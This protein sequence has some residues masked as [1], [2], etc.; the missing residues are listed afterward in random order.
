MI[1]AK[2]FSMELLREKTDGFRDPVLVKGLFADSPA[3]LK[4]K[5]RDYLA[6]SVI[7]HQ[8]I[9]VVHGAVYKKQQNNRTTDIFKNAFLNIYDNKS[10]KEYLF[11]PG[12]F[13]YV[14][15]FIL[16]PLN[17]VLLMRSSKQNRI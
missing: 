13:V 6:N 2:D 7:G 17:F 10:P 3:T 9:P 1:Q 8:E 14:F 15:T 4:W 5:D 11:F 16:L 12:K